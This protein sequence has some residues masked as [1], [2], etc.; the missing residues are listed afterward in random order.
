MVP[1][2][3]VVVG[4]TIKLCSRKLKRFVDA[5]FN[6]RPTSMK[7]LQL[8]MI[9]KD[10]G[11]LISRVLNSYKPYVDGW[12]ILDTGSTDGTQKRVA[13]AMVGVPGKLYEEPF[14]DF[15]TS[16]NR[17]IELAGKSHAFYVM[18]D[19]SYVLH[20]GKTLRGMLEKL[21]SKDYHAV[22]LRIT[23]PD[24]N[25]TYVSPRVW[26]SDANL[27]YR[28]KVH[29][30]LDIPA[31][32][33]V[34]FTDDAEVYIMDVADPTHVHR[35]YARFTSD[36]ELLL[37]A[38]SEDAKDTRTWYYLGQTL[39]LLGDKTRA[40]VWWTKV[41]GKP[42]ESDDEEAFE[43]HIQLCKYALETNDFDVAMTWA[44][45]A[46]ERCPSRS[47][48]AL[49]F[50]FKTACKRAQ[51]SSYESHHSLA[52]A[53][54]QRAVQLPYPKTA[55]S[56]IPKDIYANDIPMAY[57]GEA[58]IHHRLDD[59]KRCLDTL[60][61]TDKN[62]H[63]IDELRRAMLPF[64]AVDPPPP[65]LVKRL[66]FVTGKN[67][68]PKRWNGDTEQLGGSETSLVHFAEAHSINFD[69]HAFVWCSKEA[70]IRGV[71]Y[72]DAAVFETY[73]RDNV[74]EHLVVLRNTEYLKFTQ[75]DHIKN[76]YVWLQDTTPTIDSVVAGRNLRGFWCLSEWHVRTFQ[77]AFNVQDGFVRQMS[78]AI[79]PERFQG[80]A[81]KVPLSFVYSSHRDRNLSH[82]L[83]VF[84]KVIAAFPLATLRVVCD[85]ILP[86][87]A[88]TIRSLQ[89]VVVTP[90]VDQQTLAKI[91]MSTDY[92]VYPTDFE[93]TFCITALEAQ[94]A[95]CVVLCSDLAGLKT[96][97]GKRGILIKQAGFH[98]RFADEYLAEIKALEA[99]PSRKEGIRDLA[100]EWALRQTYEH[101][102]KNWFNKQ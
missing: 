8:V 5:L 15:S 65:P 20:G 11:P 34:S 85:D 25:L 87:D 54:I 42:L 59:A 94:A 74:I 61:V 47:A 100:R 41:A 13:D 17:A 84:R 16:R 40:K 89:A 86:N 99:D 1:K 9:V 81:K 55:L 57:V 88:E 45:N 18:P 46:C 52:F 31:G 77:N 32:K 64:N 33:A 67:T 29:E 19:D 80:V 48:E 44:L 10:S 22:L 50:A 68:T 73:A 79:V 60:V 37:S 2:D 43:A 101:H 7:L 78:N 83:T 62:S 91:M 27:K 39:D 12:C 71:T 63:A 96:T 38:H 72:H 14:V 4:R 70:K 3:K 53:F 76:V 69:V 6:P 23:Q 102:A 51:I 66:V 49:F 21:Y 56:M 35:S 98:P 93:E 58:I 26:R 28:Y 97:V 24:C 92:W 30:N 82:L 75:H 95:G 90:R 36:L